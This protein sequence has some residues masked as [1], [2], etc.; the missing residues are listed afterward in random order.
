MAEAEIEA[1]AADIKA[2]GLLFPITLCE[3]KILDGRNRELACEKAGIEPATTIYKGND[4]V[5][6]SLSVNQHRRHLP[7]HQLAFIGEELRKLER[8]TN[9]Y[10]VK[11]DRLKSRSTS[12]NNKTA[13]QIATELGID[14]KRIVDAHA[15]VTY[16]T[17]NVVAMA[18]KGEV[19]LQAAAAYVRATPQNKQIAANQEEVKRRGNILRV[20]GKAKQQKTITIPYADVVDKLRPLIKRVREQSD[21]HAATVSFMELRIIAHELKQLADSWMKNGPESETHS[22]PVPINGVS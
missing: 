9:Q 7:K 1:L 18:K 6:F 10:R 17:S 16:G 20:G 22:E 12:D 8:G 11:V 13:I 15:I 4:P 2:N 21:R 5:G 19:P 14:P 3:G